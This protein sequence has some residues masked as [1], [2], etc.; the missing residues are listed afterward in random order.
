MSISSHKIAPGDEKAAIRATVLA[1]RDGM[2]ER[3]RAEASQQVCD[4]LVALLK[5]HDGVISGYWPIRSEVDIRAALQRLQA[6]GQHVVLPVVCDRI[7][8][9]FRRYETGTTLVSAGFGTMGPDRSAPV[10]EPHVLLVPLAAF[11]V[12]GGRIGYGAGH[13]DR[14]FARLD[15]ERRRVGI[16]IAFDTQ[17]VAAAVREPHD[18]ALDWIVTPTRVVGCAHRKGD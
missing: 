7:R 2:G 14:A 11:D 15:Q 17:E 16:G 18:R 4:R 8:L 6:E 9:E 13:Y 3:E 12:D 10:I 1:R 5:D